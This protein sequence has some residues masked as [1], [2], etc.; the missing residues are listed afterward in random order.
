MSASR[1][2]LLAAAFFFTGCELTSTSITEPDD[3]LLIEAFVGIGVRGNV[4]PFASGAEGWVFV[5]GVL[6]AQQAQTGPPD[7]LI[8]MTSENG[9]STVLPEQPID[10]CVVSETPPNDP[11]R[12]Y[13]A[14]L[15]TEV[16]PGTSVTLRIETND[17]RVIT[18]ST[19]IP[20]DF[21][22]VTPVAAGHTCQLDPGTRMEISWTSSPGAWAY[23]SESRFDGLADQ[24]AL[25]DPD[26]AELADPLTVFGLAISDSDTTISYPNE[27]GVFDRFDDDLLSSA[28]VA[29]Q[30]GV[31]DGVRSLVTISAADRNWVNWE[32]GGNF[33][34]S[35]PVRVPSVSGDGFGV[36]GSM[37]LKTIGIEVG[38]LVPGR[39]ACTGV[40]SGP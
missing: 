20:R 6:G 26:F 33:N 10:R 14:P 3:A 4:G 13:A 24:L 32:R 30:N 1:V 36:F 5:H 25:Q 16:Q 22:M 35:G 39:V 17:G 15:H 27:F 18:G 28:L 21:Q 8:T 37:V 23:P 2:A 19:S 9:A 34:P 7:V 31:P 40:V 38:S 29:I 12:C 11:G